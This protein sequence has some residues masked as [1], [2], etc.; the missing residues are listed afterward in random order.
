MKVISILRLLAVL[1]AGLFLSLTTLSQVGVGTS[2]ADP[3]AM[4]DVSST[5]GGFLPPRMTVEQ[6]KVIKDPGNGLVVFCTTDNKLYVFIS[7]EDVWKEITH[8]AS[9]THQ[10]S[11]SVGTGSACLETSLYG[12]YQLGTALDSS[13]KVQLE[14]SV[15]DLGGWS[16]ITDTVNGYSFAGNGIFFSGGAQTITLYGSGTPLAGQTDQFTATGSN[17][18]GACVFSVTT[19]IP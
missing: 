8:T 9:F 18:G 11:F 14:V 13:N 19:P 16:V 10:A 6:M 17:A 5:A 12:L 3:S 7:Q 15:I 2:S 1:M 4:L